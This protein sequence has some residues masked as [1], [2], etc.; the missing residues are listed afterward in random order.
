MCWPGRW[1]DQQPLGEAALPRLPPGSRT[2]RPATTSHFLP[3]C[4]GHSVGRRGQLSPCQPGGLGLD[5]N[6]RKGL[7]EQ[8]LPQVPGAAPALGSGTIAGCCC[9][10][11]APSPGPRAAAAVQAPGGAGAAHRPR[12]PETTPSL[13]SEEESGSSASYKPFLVLNFGSL[14]SFLFPFLSFCPFVLSQGLAV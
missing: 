5:D 13:E 12:E 6:G 8:V 2:P 10:F 9:L 11:T 3:W 1:G 14:L 4:P 7:L